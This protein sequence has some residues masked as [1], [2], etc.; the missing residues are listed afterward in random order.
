MILS[1]LLSFK[2]YVKRYFTFLSGCIYRMWLRICDDVLSLNI[3]CKNFFCTAT[4]Y[5]NELIF[6]PIAFLINANNIARYSFSGFRGVNVSTSLEG[7]LN[8]CGCSLTGFTMFA[9]HFIIFNLNPDTGVCFSP[10]EI[11]LLVFSVGLFEI[12]FVFL[13]FLL[14]LPLL[15]I[16]WNTLQFVVLTNLL[17]LQLAALLFCCWLFLVF[18]W[19]LLSTFQCHLLFDNILSHFTWCKLC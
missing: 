18:L 8:H 14:S 7:A 19:S 16:H 11:I 4:S 13:S 1:F 3:V 5:L 12:L 9:D 2:A 15:L 6:T 17:V 10:S